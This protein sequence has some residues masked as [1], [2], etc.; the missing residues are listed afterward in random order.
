MD[1]R[2]LSILESFRVLPALQESPLGMRTGEEAFC[3]C[4][5][6]AGGS[7]CEFPWKYD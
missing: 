3:P 6:G 7:F 1:W 2:A 4:V 5:Y